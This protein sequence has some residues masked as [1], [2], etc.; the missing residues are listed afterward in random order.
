MFEPGQPPRTIHCP[1]NDGYFGEL[2]C[3]VQCIR[4]G[5]P[6]ARVTAADGLGAVEICQAEGEIDRQRRNCPAVS[7]VWTKARLNLEPTP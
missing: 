1:G 5:T 7:G 2:Q 6:P 4:Q 3:M